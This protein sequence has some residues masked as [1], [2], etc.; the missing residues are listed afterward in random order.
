MSDKKE[1]LYL[2]ERTGQWTR[3]FVSLEDLDQLRTQGLIDD[4]TPCI[5]RLMARRGPKATGVAYSSISRLPIEFSP[6]I[7]TLFAS[8]EEQFATIFCGPNNCGKTLLLKQL[9]THAGE[10]SYL[11]SCNRFSH[12][13]VL[14]TRQQE[15]A[16]YR[17]Y[18]NNFVQ[19]WYTVKQNTEDTEFKL[20]QAITG[21]RNTQRAHLFAICRDILG[22]EFSL[23]R[24]QPDNDFSP[25]YV[26]MDRQ[27][28]RYGSTG[29]RLL[30]TL[31][32]TILNEQF[33][34]LLIDEPE[35]GLSPKSQ[36]A[37]ANLLFDL[38]NRTRYWPHLQRVYIAT[39]SH[40]FLDRRAI[41]NNY[42][43]QRMGTKVTTRPVQSMS[44]F[45]QV[46]FNMRY[47]L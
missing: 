33:Q 43:V 40:L 36:S 15:E 11:V 46:Q 6:D 18:Y 5:T 14:N 32:G 7:E 41:G 19:N 8:R 3:E 31:L 2:D 17:N 4:A 45:H 22:S 28:L 24:T 21:L 23:K 20:E 44:E 47:H 13:D 37:V 35:I 38:D 10:G 16:Q 12:I 9:Y 30:L 29:T 39:H 25:F 27:N 26:E 42:L 1:W 34:T